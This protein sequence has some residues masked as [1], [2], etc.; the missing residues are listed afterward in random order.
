MEIWAMYTGE[1]LEPG[2]G[3]SMSSTLFER[4]MEA[5]DVAELQKL[6]GGVELISRRSAIEELQRRGKIRVTTSVDEELQRLVD[7]TPEPAE[8]P[9]RNDLG[10]VGEPEP[11]P[12]S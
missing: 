6:A 5:A 3:L 1:T 9:D 12:E 2:A 10:E 4:P 7:E 8:E 11:E